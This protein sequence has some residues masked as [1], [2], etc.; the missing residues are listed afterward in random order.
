[1]PPDS[2][3]DQGIL[4]GRRPVL[5][6]LRSGRSPERVLIAQGLAP[7]GVLGEIRR[8]A[9]E[10]GVPVRSVPR[11]EVDRIAAGANHQGVAALV[12]RYRYSSLDD[13]LAGSDP[14]LLFL[15]GVTDPQNLGSLLRSAE[16]AGFD[17]V[18]IPTHRAAGV[19]PAVRRVSAGAAE[20][21]PVARVSSLG[22]AIEAARARGLWILGLDE[23]AEH[24]IWAS[25]LTEPPVGLVLG[26]EGRGISSSIRDRCDDI[27]RIPH[28][29]RIG[30]L[31]VA[32]AGAIAMF[33]V[34]RRRRPSVT[35]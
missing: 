26:S 22:N 13:L 15:D 33:E 8:R 34:A 30:S 1:M 19:T 25:R 10:R 23:K 11:Q 4:I 5:E 20:L 24:D 3:P 2:T 32:V 14:T 12:G 21:V 9:G 18:V 6:L 29:G 28:R 7:S 16:G 27:A 17:G 35:L 31:N